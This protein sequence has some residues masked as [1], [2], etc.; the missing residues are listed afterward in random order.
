MA[1]KG[2]Q[3]DRVTVGGWSAAAGWCE[4]TDERC[5]AG[6]GLKS[7]RAG[8]LL[9]LRCRCQRVMVD[10]G[11]AR[12]ATRTHPTQGLATYRHAVVHALGAETPT[13]QRTLA[14]TRTG[15]SGCV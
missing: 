6:S 11:A 13:G 14:T 12:A 9:G 10:G 4:C 2:V 8:D 15:L 7:R 3:E 1:L 5:W